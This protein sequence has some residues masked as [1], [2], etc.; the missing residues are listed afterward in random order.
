MANVLSFGRYPEESVLYVSSDSG[1]QAGAVS[2]EGLQESSI[3]PLGTW[4][5][6]DF[7]IPKACKLSVLDWLKPVK[8]K[9]AQGAWG[10]FHDAVHWA[11]RHGLAQ[12]KVVARVKSGIGVESKSGEFRHG[13]D[14]IKKWASDLPEPAINN[15]RQRDE[16][17]NNTRTETRRAGDVGQGS[18]N[19]LNVRIT[20]DT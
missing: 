17:A 12:I 20:I 19:R 13:A 16:E 2:L 1:T 9:G 6:E 11:N 5:H 4:E 14:Y 7:E 3:N 8:C 18:N 10:N 15:A